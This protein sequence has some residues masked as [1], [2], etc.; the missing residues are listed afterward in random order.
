MYYQHQVENLLAVFRT[1]VH[2]SDF[3]ED[4]HLG[5]SVYGMFVSTF[6]VLVQ[7]PDISRG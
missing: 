5:L 3:L 2:S 7:I 1:T 4:K 6:A